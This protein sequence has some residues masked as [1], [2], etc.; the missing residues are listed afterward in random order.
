MGQSR[1]FFFPNRVRRVKGAIELLYLGL[2]L[3]FFN[4]FHL[5]LEPSSFKIVNFF[6]RIDRYFHVFLSILSRRPSCFRFRK[7]YS[8]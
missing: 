3:R 2:S 4:E 7:P 6:E 8:F 5:A 1:V